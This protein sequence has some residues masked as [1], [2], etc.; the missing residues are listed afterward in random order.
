MG[1]TKDG[2]TVGAVG[3]ARL[4]IE[5]VSLFR[6]FRTFDDPRL[7]A[8]TVAP[9]FK[10]ILGSSEMQKG[11]FH[12]KCGKTRNQRQSRSRE[13]RNQVD[14][15]ICGKVSRTSVWPGTP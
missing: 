15:A 11:Y 13:Q 4:S 9:V 10:A 2:D 7:P 12:R 1:K 8:R 6:F 14:R 3:G 5:S